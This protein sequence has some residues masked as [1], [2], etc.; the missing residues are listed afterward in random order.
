MRGESWAIMFTLKNKADPD[1]EFTGEMQRHAGGHAIR[2]PSEKN[3][4]LID[5]AR[6]AHENDAREMDA[7][8][9]VDWI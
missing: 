4:H 6:Y 7:G 3:N 2:K 5:A 9:M 8:R 1:G